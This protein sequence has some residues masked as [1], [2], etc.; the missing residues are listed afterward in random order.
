VEVAVGFSFSL[1][2]F[3]PL[4]R[5]ANN[6][7]RRKTI[8]KIANARELNKESRRQK[9]KKTAHETQGK[10]TQNLDEA[11]RSLESETLEEIS[12]VQP[13]GKKKKERT[14]KKGR[15]RK[16]ERKRKRMRKKS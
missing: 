8:R 10:R 13:D 14:K 9:K 12:P 2:F 7:A 5:Q 1:S 15:K 16:E 11:N 4:P 6:G 3:P